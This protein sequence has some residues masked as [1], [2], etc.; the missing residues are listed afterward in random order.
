MP[1]TLQALYGARQH[2]PAAV[3]YYIGKVREWRDLYFYYWLIRGEGESILV[4]TGVPINKP[5][6]FDILNRSHQYVGL[7]ALAR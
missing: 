4:D 1:Y 2:S 7:T 3:W 5:E 6:D